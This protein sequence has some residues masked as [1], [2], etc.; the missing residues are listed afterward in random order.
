MVLCDEKSELMNA[1]NTGAVRHRG[2]LWYCMGR[3][4]YVPLALI[5]CCVALFKHVAF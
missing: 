5:L 1:V 3:C 2:E 4:V